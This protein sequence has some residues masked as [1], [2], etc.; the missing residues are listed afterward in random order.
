MAT[1]SVDRR[2]PDVGRAEEAM[3]VPPSAEAVLGG[4]GGHVQD[5]RS[6]NSC[7]NRFTL[8][9]L[10]KPH[11]VYSRVLVH[12]MSTSV[13]DRPKGRI[14]RGGVEGMS[15]GQGRNVW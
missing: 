2:I 3:Q 4:K 10:E 11:D 9:R 13:R 1:L 6:C 7:K 8:I 12:T 15:G 14:S 5:E